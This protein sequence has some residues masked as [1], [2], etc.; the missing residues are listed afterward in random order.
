MASAPKQSERGGTVTVGDRTWKI[1]PSIQCS[2]YPGDVVSIA[3]HAESDPNLEIVIDNDPNGPSGVRIG[4]SGQAVNWHSE[5]ESFSIQINGKQVHGSA[6]FTSYSSE[7]TVQGE[8]KV[9]C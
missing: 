7:E 5:R 3:G 1:V 4:G 6:V 8:F 2:I 9:D